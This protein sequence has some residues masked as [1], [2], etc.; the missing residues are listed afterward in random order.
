MKA[1][2]LFSFILSFMLTSCNTNG[3]QEI[4][5]VPKNYKGYI[6]IVFNQEDGVPAKYE[7]KKRV[8]EIP[9]SGVLRTQF[10]VNDGGREFA[11]YYYDKIAPENKLPS[12]VEIK[13]VPTD[14][15][16]GFMGANGT[17]KKSS[18]SEERLE[19]CEFYIG[20]KADIE[21]AQGQVEKL[22]FVKLAE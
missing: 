12:F 8:Y 10:K 7:G 17:V 6:I 2:V 14:T 1:V 22:D 5:V 21:Q 19:F 3:E 4:I 13:K 11:E 20:T 9:Q 16:V 15:V 18:K